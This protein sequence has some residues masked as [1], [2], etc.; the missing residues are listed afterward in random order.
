MSPATGRIFTTEAQMED[1]GNESSDYPEDATSENN[2][3]LRREVR[4][5]FSREVRE[6]TG[7]VKMPSGCPL[8]RSV[9]SDRNRQYRAR[10]GTRS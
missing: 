5:R 8:F 6:R 10:S 9:S 3:K 2:L 7:D 1:I 4:K